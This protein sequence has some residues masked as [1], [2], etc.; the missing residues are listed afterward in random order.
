MLYLIP[1]LCN[2]ILR[3]DTKKSNNF[4]KLFNRL[5]IHLYSI[6]K[7]KEGIW[8][9]LQIPI[10]VIWRKLETTWQEQTSNWRS[11]LH[12]LE[13]HGIVAFSPKVITCQLNYKSALFLMLHK[14]VESSCLYNATRR[15]NTHTFL[16]LF[17]FFIKTIV[18]NRKMRICFPF[19][20]LQMRSQTRN[21]TLFAQ[22]LFPTSAFLVFWVM[23]KQVK[24]EQ[25]PF[26]NIKAYLLLW[27][28]KL[29]LLKIPQ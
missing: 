19:E 21:A 22:F 11:W 8:I 15:T 18:R 16:L 7:D 5:C 12:P 29:L 24:R 3:L 20:K 9:T 10:S 2:L 23:D 26:N 17:A 28:L 1:I 27:A 13:K 6:Y 4:L 25:V 14:K